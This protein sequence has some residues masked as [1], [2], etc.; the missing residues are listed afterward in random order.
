MPIWAQN[1]EIRGKVTD[2]VTKEPMSS[3]SV[4]LKGTNKSVS[5]DAEGYYTISVPVGSTLQFSFIG[6]T[7]IEKAVENDLILSVELQE[8]AE[9]LDEAIV[10]ALGYRREKETLPYS[11]GVV[12]SENLTFAKSNDISTSLAGKVSGIQLQGSPSST[13]DNANVVIR[14]ANTLGTSTQT[15]NP[16]YILDGTPT[17]QQNII[18]DNVESVSVLKGAAATALYGQRAANGVILMTSKKGKRGV[19]TIDVNLSAAIENAAILY[20]TQNEYG[21]GYKSTVN[22]PGSSYDAEGFVLFSYKEG[23]HPTSWAPF[24]GQRMIEYGADESWGPKLNGQAYRPYYSWYA[25]PDFGNL[26]SFSLPSSSSKDFYKTGTNFNNS[27]A[28]SGGGDNYLYR[29]TYANQNRSLIIPEAKRNQHQFGMN[30]SLDVSKKLTVSAD[31]S[32]TYYNTKGQPGEG[33]DLTG[34]NVSQNINQW[35]QRQLDVDRLK[36]YRNADGTYQSWNIGDPNSYDP[37]NPTGFLTPQYWDS[38]YFVVDKNYKTD[39]SN[40]FVGNVGVNYKFNDYL[41]WQSNARL[42]YR[43]T[44]GDS[45]LAYGGFNTNYYQIYQNINRETNFETN[46]NYKRVFGDFSVDALL[47]GNIRKNYLNE[48]KEASNGG[49]TFPDYFDIGN[50]SI[51]RPTITRD[52]GRKEIRSVYGR[53]S[54]GYKTLLFVDASLRTDW[55][56]AIPSQNNPFSYPSVGGSFLFTELIKNNG[57]RHVINTGKLRASWAQ[58]GADLDPFGVY[59]TTISRPI[60]NATPSA[61]V[62]NEFRTG[63]IKPALTTSWEIGTDLRM[64]NFLNIEFTYYQDDNKDQILSLDV[65]PTTGFNKYQINAGMIQRKGFEIGLSAVPLQ[66]DLTWSVALNFGRNRSKIVELADG[67][68]TYLVGTERANTRLEHR[69]GEEWGMLYGQ[70]WRRDEQGRVLIDATGTPLID[71]NQKGGTVAPDFTGGFIN[72]FKYQNFTLSFSLDFQKGGL[73]HSRTALHGVGAGQHEMTVGVNDKGVDWRE[74]PSAGGGIRIDGVYG[75][76]VVIGGVDMSGQPNETYIAASR[77]FNSA[78]Q[79]DNLNTN[80]LSA[81]YVKLREVRLGYNLPANIFGKQFKNANIGFT[82]NNAWLI[83]S[84]AARDFGIDPSELEQYWYEG[85]QLPQTRSFG[86]NL[87]A[88]F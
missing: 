86:L 79:G 14:G 47:G 25:G 35:W 12:T 59:T 44:E 60:Y 37:T 48:L 16:L 10:T 39:N 6:Y 34:V 36:D 80:I 40:R 63:N 38:P 83:Y 78:R 43:N 69:V 53:A 68:D 52:Y 30:S 20:P 26:G 74:F 42:S 73:F 45:R 15:N 66:G 28:F 58:V 81:T 1:K 9:M 24:D 23:V 19:P 5:T 85:G 54:I 22:S 50:G 49:L 62:G 61:E 65:D 32:Y 2:F 46:L 7:T 31:I 75:P 29:F 21:G 11:V 84:P 27:I 57:L 56:S 71:Q 17:E 51:S 55:S 77:Y 18:M 64:F 4:K 88:S 3:V 72:N 33:Y 67:L 87:R 8:D 70:M 76:G 13:F 82:V 41:S